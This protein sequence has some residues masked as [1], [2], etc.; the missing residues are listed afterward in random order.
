MSVFAGTEVALQ[1]N[2]YCETKGRPM[3]THHYYAIIICGAYIAFVIVANLITATSDKQESF[4][5]HFNIAK[6]TEKLFVET[7]DPLSQ[8]IAFVHGVRFYYQLTVI[9]AHICDIQPFLST[10]YRKSTFILHFLNS[11][12][13]PTQLSSTTVIMD[14]SRSSFIAAPARSS[15]YRSP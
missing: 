5:E 1:V 15:K 10:L 8:R 13:R 11:Y 7:K 9:A 6:N 2:P 14:G 12:D 4:F 3:A